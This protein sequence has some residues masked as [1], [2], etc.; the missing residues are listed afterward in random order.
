MKI[1]STSE[2]HERDGTQQHRDALPPPK[3]CRFPRRIKRSYRNFLRRLRH[4]LRPFLTLRSHPMG[5][6]DDVSNRGSVQASMTDSQER[7]D[8]LL[9]RNLLDAQVRSSVVK[10]RKLAAQKKTVYPLKLSSFLSNTK[11]HCRESGTT[12]RL[13]PARE[14]PS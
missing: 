5:F 2:M 7:R 10:V 12:R 6:A 14:P 3:R 4:F 8:L 13:H 11:T 9:A 1:I